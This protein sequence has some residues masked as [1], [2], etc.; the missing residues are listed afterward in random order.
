MLEKGK[1]RA[2]TQESPRKF[3]HNLQSA[4]KPIIMQTQ[5]DFNEVWNVTFQQMP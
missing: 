1:H 3:A 5:Q 4:F 2:G